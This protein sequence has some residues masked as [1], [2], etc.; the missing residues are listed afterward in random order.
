MSTARHRRDGMEGPGE[1]P[2]KGELVTARN[3]DHQNR[4]LRGTGLAHQVLNNVTC[5]LTGQRLNYTQITDAM[6]IIL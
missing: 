3:G 4:W 2:L 5:V 1:E 6:A